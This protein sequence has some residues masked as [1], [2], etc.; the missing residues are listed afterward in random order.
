VEPT[1]RPPAPSMLT[2]RTDALSYHGEQDWS[3]SRGT[4]LGCLSLPLYAPLFPNRLV[5]AQCAQSPPILLVIACLA[6]PLPH[7]PSPSVIPAEAGIQ[8]QP[9]KALLGKFTAPRPWAYDMN[10]RFVPGSC[11]YRIC[12]CKSSAKQLTCESRH[13]AAAVVHK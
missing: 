4:R 1:Q 13:T 9:R 6:P 5:P 3:I 12:L 2:C 11:I 7:F 10:E 8:R